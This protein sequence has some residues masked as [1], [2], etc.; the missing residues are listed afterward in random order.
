MAYVKRVSNAINTSNAVN[1]QVSTLFS[2]TRPATQPQIVFVQQL[3][4]LRART[5]PL[6]TETNPLSS[7]LVVFENGDKLSEVVE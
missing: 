3:E 4:L 7:E 5:Q 6:L 1:N 2:L